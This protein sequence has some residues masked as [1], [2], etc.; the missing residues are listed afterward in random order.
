M[1]APRRIGC[2]TRIQALH[3]FVYPVVCNDRVNDRSKEPFRHVRTRCT[4]RGAARV[5]RWIQAPINKK[6]R[7]PDAENR[8]AKR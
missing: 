6:I 8:K 3:P 7:A 1:C 2:M 5:G 4:T